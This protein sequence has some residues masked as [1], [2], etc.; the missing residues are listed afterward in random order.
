ML[1]PHRQVCLLIAVGFLPAISALAQSP[2]QVEFFEAKIRPIFVEKC[3]GCHNAKVKTA[4]L[5]LST[6]AGFARGG[7]GGPIVVKGD[8]EHSRLI[9]AVNYQSD[10]KMPPTG[11]LKDEQIAD[12]TAWVKMG[13]PWQDVSG[14]AVL[15]PQAPGK[16]VF[17]PEQRA[18]W[19]FQPVRNYPVP[20][21]RSKTWVKDPI[22]AFI[23]A[24][25]E[26]KGLK[27]SRP[28]DKLA[29][30][31]RATF[32]LI[33][34]SPT[35]EEVDA[36]LNDTFPSAF[37]KVVDR[38]LASPRYGE[39]WGRHWLDI[40]R[41]ADST[42][43]DE[44]IRYPYA[45][46]YRDYVID[47]FNSDMPYNQFV[48]EQLAGD[49]LPADKP[50]GVN[51]RGIIATS[52]LG[53]GLKLLAE[54]DKPK[55][56]YDMVDE[57][58]DTTT[59]AFMG[60]TVA[61]ARCHDHKFDPI[62]TKDY[63]SLVS[64]FAST[65]SLAKVEG[66]VSQIYFAPLVP[67]DVYKHY[68]DHETLIKGKSK[69]IQRVT[70]EEAESY[71]APLRSRVAEYM[72]GAWSYD[73]RPA[74]QEHLCMEDYARRQNLKPDLLR[75]WNEF[76][77][78]TDDF[79]PYL[80]RW[81]AAGAKGEAAIRETAAQYQ[82]EFDAS[83]EEWQKSI[84]PWWAKVDEA[85]TAHM[86]PPDRPRFEAGHNRFF[87]A[88]SF[89]KTGPF[90]FVAD[91]EDMPEPALT[92]AAIEDGTLAVSA[93]AKARLKVL[94]EELAELKKTMPPEPDMACG[95]T[96]GAPVQQHVLIRGNPAAKGDE[97]PKQFLQ[98][99]AG[100]HQTPITQG[101]GRLE[102]AKWLT[103]PKHPLTSRVMVNR[104]WEY[105]FGEGLVRTPTNFGRLGETP[106][107][108]ELFDYLA[109]QFIANGWSIK[110]LHREIMLSSTYQMSSAISKEQAEADPSNKLLS[111]FS[112]RRLDVEE[113]RDG[114]LALNGKLDL[115]MFGTLQKGFGTDGEN[116][117]AR[118]SIDPN[119]SKRRTVY[120]PIRR[121]NLSSLFNLFDFGDATTP[122]EGRS[123][124][125]V[126]PQALF[127][128]NSK[129]IAE[130]SSEMAR[131]L[132]DAKNL[133]D[134]ARVQ[135][136]VYETLGHKPD[137]EET[138]D[139]LGYIDSFQK[140]AMDSQPKLDDPK[141]RAWESFCHVLI[142]SNGFIYVD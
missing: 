11:K 67:A 120:L 19:A 113:I 127:M 14:P 69:E 16:Y 34:L 79:R 7:G 28:A 60:M 41:Y 13:A 95:V 81:I 22:D 93:A 12:L 133:D 122:S 109:S 140:K 129:F 33:G 27:P 115:T 102:L 45:W 58:V 29:L 6:P 104:I 136:A 59:R 118:K 72:V 103:D 24:R 4:G 111:H 83:T 124:T 51:R 141:F 110:K 42:G 80:E 52:F 105:H 87:G 74:A 135:T 126:A 54:Q 61:C 20:T 78:P 85:V 23:L 117:E 8:P 31:R 62:P 76:L 63:Y 43:A 64:I 98:I 132:L 71:A 37:A 73:H 50:G 49:L 68:T 123:R 99:I 130:R 139:L 82:K 77:T 100:E 86:E 65:K 2:E 138:H 5:D 75:S 137:S 47:A 25:L 21:V 106:S 96:E 3:S 30:L 108:P 17:S 107:H 94:R 57:Q 56:V 46:R 134:T 44:D 48:T 88:V 26:E 121:S 112:R 84:K 91:D 97:V 116:G 35:P 142:A 89:D 70:S 101:S 9:D 128:M 10:N 90:T 92:Q 40:A 55:M 1:M 38:L 119:T 18:F 53:I 39:R 36:F 66:T 125:N 15:A 32:D 131:H 114:L